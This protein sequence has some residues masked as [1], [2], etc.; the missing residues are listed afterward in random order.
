MPTAA[1]PPRRRPLLRL[2]LAAG[3]A[4]AMATGI[5]LPLAAAW[6]PP[7]GLDASIFDGLAPDARPIPVGLDATIDPTVLAA[8]TN[9][10]PDRAFAAEWRGQLVVTVPGVHHLR[11]RADDGVAVWVDGAAVIDRLDHRGELQLSEALRLEPGLHPIRIR[12]E[13]LGGDAV[14][15]VWCSSPLWREEWDPIHARSVPPEVTFDRVLLAER[16][17]RLLSVGWSIWILL[18]LVLAGAAMLA[19]ATA[20]E[21][22][23]SAIG[24]SEIVPLAAVAVPLLALNL[25]LGTAPWR[26]WSPDEVVPRQA[27]EGWQYRFA[28]GWSNMYPPLP[29]ML[30]MVVNAPIVLLNGSGSVES[31][32][33]LQT[34]THLVSRG[35]SLGFAWLGL[36]AVSLLAQRTVN[37]RARV[38][39]PYVVLGLPLFAFYAKT[40]N[41]ETSY[42]FWVLAGALAFLRA[43]AT[44]S[45]AAHAWLGLFAAWS[46]ATKDQAYGFWVAP[47]LALLWRAWRDSDGRMVTRVVSTVL[48]RGLWVGAVSCLFVY[49]V[50]AGAWWNL[51]GLRAH[52]GLITGRGATPFRMFPATA[53]GLE[54]LAATSVALTGQVM[55]PV[56][57]VLT[58]LGLAVLFTSGGAARRFLLVLS[59]PIGYWLAFV[60]VVG[61][62]YDR[63][64]IVG[65]VML[66]LAAAT[67]WGWILD[68]LPQTRAGTVV[69]A[70]LF[71]LVL[72]PTVALNLQL[73]GDSR[74]HAERWMH[75][76]LTNDPLVLGTGTR[77]YLP[78]LFPF[79]HRL[80]TRASPDNLLAWD[81][82]VIVLQ[83][84]WFGRPRQPALEA[85]REALGRSGYSEQFADRGPDATTWLGVLWSGLR[86]NPE[87]S[88]LTKFDPPLAIWVRARRDTASGGS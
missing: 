72:A 88:N 48:N 71:A 45:V 5:G 20:I 17:P 60:G 41:L 18:G 68:R 9:I 78:N 27:F 19:R 15:R 43:V 83:E 81:A 82:D 25:T 46:V 63:F 8:H 53:E 28:G 86:I 33:T 55:G 49:S 3:A 66:T 22:I 39:A 21:R 59:I 50:L 67:G 13:Q 35:L 26:A 12:Y 11:V 57:A 16:V 38:L 79:R 85:V 64:L 47:A 76:T 32:A 73:G 4:L 10:E 36:L 6:R 80:E 31:D 40:Y 70:L 65:V 24:W 29:F 23:T 87:F 42:T 52:V 77:L 75:E 2:W 54:R 7:V 1:A 56:A 51:D 30:F 58:I 69:R 34:L 61:F 44:G 62:V 84:D 14:L 74:V 37:G